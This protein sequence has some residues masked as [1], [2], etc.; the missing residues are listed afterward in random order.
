MQPESRFDGV[1]RNE[2]A[3]KPMPSTPLCRSSAIQCHAKP[4]LDGRRRSRR[5][6]A[7]HG[8]QLPHTIV[9]GCRM[10]SPCKLVWVSSRV[11]VLPANDLSSQATLSSSSRDCQRVVHPH[12]GHGLRVHAYDPS[13]IFTGAFVHFVYHTIVYTRHPRVSYCAAGRFSMH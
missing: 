8:L 5:P 2:I 11:F 9:V 13:P 6:A 4:T 7:V 1:S 10:S 3:G 12:R